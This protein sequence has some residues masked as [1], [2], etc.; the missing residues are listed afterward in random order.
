MRNCATT[1]V[2]AW[3]AASLP[4]CVSRCWAITF[5]PSTTTAVPAI[6]AK[7]ARTKRISTCPLAPLR[8]LSDKNTITTLLTVGERGGW[9][10]VAA[11]PLDGHLGSRAQVGRADDLPDDRSDR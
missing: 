7:K 6:S 4:F 2:P 8:P 5:P 3:A 10:G 1:T 11:Y 9:R